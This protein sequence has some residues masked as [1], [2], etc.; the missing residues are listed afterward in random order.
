MSWF[1]L[2]VA[3]YSQNLF[4]KDVFLQIGWLPPG[5]SVNAMTETFRVARAQAAARQRR[6]EPRRL[7]DRQPQHLAAID[8]LQ[9]TGVV[10]E[11]LAITGAS[12]GGYMSAWAIG[13]TPRFRA[14]VVCAPVA[15]L[16]SH[17]GS[18]DSGYHPAAPD[19]Q[20]DLL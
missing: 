15:N 3:F 1:L 14:A 19:Q 9:R 10:D 17:F 6:G 12:Y 13:H 5:E 7:A 11:R 4:Q 2:D 20:G 8:Q 16:E 18:S